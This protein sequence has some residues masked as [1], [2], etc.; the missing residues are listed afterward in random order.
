MAARIALLLHMHQ[1]DYIDPETGEPVMPWVRLHAT[2][3]YLDVPVLAAE[4]GARWTLNV[5]PS[6]LDQLEGYVA[7][8]TD[9]WERLSRQEAETLSEAAIAFL[10][11]RFF[12]GHPNM[13]R[14]S[15]RYRELE[16]RRAV[17]SDPQDLRDLQVWSNLSWMGVVARRD[18]FVAGLV[19]QD[20]AF[21]HPQ[22][23]KLMDVQRSLVA[24]VLPLWRDAPEISCSPYNH[25][26]LPL[27]V[28]FEHARRSLPH[29]P[30]GSV[31][32]AFPADASRQVREG[33]DRVAE[34]LGRRP[35]GMWPSE[36]SVGPEVA[37]LC[38][39]EGV[40]WLATDEGV[41]HASTRDFFPSVK[42][43]WEVDGTGMKMVFRSRDL[44]DRIGFQYASW[45]GRS[46]ADDLLAAVG[47]DGVVPIV[48]DGENPW[49]SFA[50]AGE[51]FLHHL[52]SSGRVCAIGDAVDEMP[53]QR[54]HHLHTGSWIHAH[55]GIW[56]G[57]PMDRAGWRRLAALR[58]AW[59][60][61]GQPEAAWPHIRAAEGSDWFWW[62]GPE[63][64]TE[65]R[66][67]FDRLFNAHLK[68]G[69]RALGQAPP[70]ELDQ[71]VWCDLLELS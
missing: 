32:F 23:L 8:G 55:L 9:E 3:G 66:D 42:R 61:A 47:D 6:L 4:R 68:A 17:L 40:R 35:D 45:D 29:V 70:A 54:I 2:R 71:P 22:L 28:D 48:L 37:L 59:R 62:Y 27:L 64:H 33:L 10:R 38:A 49:E 12:H 31:A 46:A 50:D 65:M 7:G 30:P 24:R 18:P 39:Q 20:R 43:V 26:I 1:P 41:L 36:G 13:R 16:G 11:E 51:S 15:P 25:P 21:T 56:A 58:A 67:L 63:H 19:A 53:T 60:D 69:W 52:F 44:S 34:V 5:V 57:D 14:T